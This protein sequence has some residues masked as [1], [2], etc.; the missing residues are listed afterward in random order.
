MEAVTGMPRIMAAEE[1]KV[2][3]SHVYGCMSMYF[4]VLYVS[5]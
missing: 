1:Q 2:G 4:C 5:V 3:S